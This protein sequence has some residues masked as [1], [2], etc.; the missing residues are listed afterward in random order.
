MGSGNEF[1]YWDQREMLMAG[2]TWTEIKKMKL[3]RRGGSVLIISLKSLKRMRLKSGKYSLH[4]DHK[5]RFN[6]LQRIKRV[7]K[8]GQVALHDG[9]VLPWWRLKTV[10]E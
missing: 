10:G 7:F 3:Y 9:S 8:N 6:R 5:S 1:T 2:N 4:I